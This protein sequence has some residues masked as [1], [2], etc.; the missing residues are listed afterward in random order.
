MSDI[1]IKILNHF[2]ALQNDNEAENLMRF[3]KTGKGEYGEGDK[4][5]GIRVPVTRSIVKEYK[6]MV[7]CADI[8]P[9]FDSCYHEVRLAGF[10]LLVE[11]YK[12]AKRQRNEAMTEYIVDLYLSK[13]ERGNN[14]D[15][16][17]LVAPKILGDRL[18]SNPSQRGILDELADVQSI[19]H[20]RVAVVSN[21]TLIREHDFDYT[22]RIVKKLL[23][24]PH[25][26]I[27]KA[28]GW[29]L[30]EVG[31][32][33]GADRLK[34]FLEEYAPTMPRT[35]LRYSIERFPEQERKHYLTL[36]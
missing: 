22:F 25:D 4:F 5:L 35:T 15:L 16:V 2:L 21:W 20:Q 27:Q 8:L 24:H 13:I 10:L 34:A 19:W 11:L 28:N 7:E 3:F 9:L 29:M 6:K 30:R 36:K 12:S 14:W 23:Y 26:L 18:M 32:R 1:T 33:G 17:D 31:K